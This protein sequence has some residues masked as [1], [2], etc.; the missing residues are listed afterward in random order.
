MFCPGS[1]Y[2]KKSDGR[3]VMLYSIGEIIDRKFLKKF[4]SRPQ[5]LNF[6][7]ELDNNFEIRGRDLFNRLKIEKTETERLRTRYEI[8]VWFK[9]IY[10]YGDKT[11]SIVSLMNVMSGLFFN[12][13]EEAKGEILEQS[14]ELFKRSAICGSYNVISAIAIGFSDFKLLQD[15]FNLAFFYDIGVP[16]EERTLNYFKLL[17]VEREQPGK[18]I[19][20]FEANPNLVNLTNIFKRRGEMAYELVSEKYKNYFNY[21]ALISFLRLIGERLDGS[22][23]PHGIDEENLGELESMLLLVNHLISYKQPVFSFG[24]GRLFFNKKLRMHL[25]GD[26]EFRIKH[27]LISIFDKLPRSVYSNEGVA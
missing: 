8:L 24:D 1:L 4:E 3:R 26:F 7:D 17:E 6:F 25:Y 20:E 2:W 18:G 22:G 19:F 10:W 12:F 21:Q 11:G 15:I 23:Y 14:F 5:V 27:F 13:N 16:F 9:D